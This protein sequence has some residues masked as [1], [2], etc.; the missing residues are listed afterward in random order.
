[1]KESTP[2]KNIK[3][4]IHTRDNKSFVRSW[5]PEK[6]GDDLSSF[7]HSVVHVNSKKEIVNTFEV[8]KAGLSIRSV[9]PIFANTN[10]HVGS[11]EFMQGINSVAIEFDKN[12]DAFILLMDSSVAV[13]DTSKLKKLHDY[14][15]S[16]K[17]LNEEF[18]EDAKKIDFKKLLKDGYIQSEKYFYTF[19][20]I[21]DFEDKTIG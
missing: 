16:Q 9:V 4:H 5:L 20:N 10:E 18:Y 11:L 14:V 8:G 12:A 3:V 2:F 19:T 15:V 13:A 1:M 17:F 7:R 6:F 21:K